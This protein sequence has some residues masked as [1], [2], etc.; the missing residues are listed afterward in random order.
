MV[1]QSPRPKR[2]LGGAA[3]AGAVQRPVRYPKTISLMVSE[4]LYDDIAEVALETRRSK[5]DVARD[6]LERGR[7]S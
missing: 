6:W 7:R 2:A 5:A 1:N 3:I 4:D